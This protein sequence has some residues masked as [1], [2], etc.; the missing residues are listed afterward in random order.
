MS[1]GLKANNGF[2]ALAYFNVAWGNMVTGFLL[3]NFSSTGVMIA[4]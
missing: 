3:T 4:D 1:E 2:L